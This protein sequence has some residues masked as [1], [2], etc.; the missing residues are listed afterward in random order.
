MG[1]AMAE[2]ISAADLAAMLEQNP[3]GVVVID[4]RDKERYAAGHV[5][6]AVHIPLAKL[7]EATPELPRNRTIVTYCGGGTSGPKAAEFLAQRG[8]DVRV[9][10]G[11][12]AWQAAGLPVATK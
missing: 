5:P 6:G 12:R 4:V 2:R 8:Y 1:S 11:F 9:M 3:E 7:M 10:E